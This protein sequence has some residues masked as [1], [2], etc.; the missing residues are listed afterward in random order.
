MPPSVPPTVP[1]TVPPHDDLERTHAVAAARARAHAKPRVPNVK[2]EEQTEQERE[3]EAVEDDSDEADGWGK[4]LM[5]RRAHEETRGWQR[6]LGISDGQQQVLAAATEEGH[7]LPRQNLPTPLIVRK[8]F[9]EAPVAMPLSSRFSRLRRA[10]SC[11]ASGQG[12]A[13]ERC[14]MSALQESEDEEAAM[15]AGAARQTSE[16]H[17]MLPMQLLE[18]ATSSMGSVKHDSRRCKPCAFVHTDAGCANGTACRFCHAC[19]PGEK[20]RRQKAKAQQ[21]KRRLYFQ[22]QAVEG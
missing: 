2:K 6:R 22:R 10:T 15:A 16:A 20:K 9:I 19:S 4:V 12:V 1:P 11:P 7:A 18:L 13:A 14:F 17:W 5:A 21:R 8:T 3:E